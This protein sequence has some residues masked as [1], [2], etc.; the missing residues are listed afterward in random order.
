MVAAAHLGDGG[1]RLAALGDEACG[2]R[3]QVRADGRGAGGDGRGGLFIVGVES[4]DGH[5]I[6]AE[7]SNDNVNVGLAARFVGPRKR[8]VVEM[9]LDAWFLQGQAPG[10]GAPLALG[11]TVGRD[12]RAAD[13]GAGGLEG[14]FDKPRDGVVEV[15]DVPAVTED[16]GHVSLLTDRLV[17]FSDQGRVAEDVAASLRRQ[18]FFQSRRSALPETMVGNFFQLDAA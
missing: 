4:L 3:S 8:A 2:T 6:V 7:S 11:D 5:V 13:G 10:D 1:D 18:D 15:A 9:D 17:V 12:E 14:A 16:L